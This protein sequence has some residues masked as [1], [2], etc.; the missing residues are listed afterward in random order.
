MRP[1]EERI[2]LAQ[3]AGTEELWKIIRDPHPDV[4]L[5]ATLNRNLEEEMAVFIARRKTTS[6]EALGY[7]ANDIRFK[8]SYKLKLAICRN[9]R[10]PQKVTLSLLKFIRLFDLSDLA[11][12]QHIPVSIRQ[13]IEHDLSQKIP[14]LPSGVKTALAR[15]AGSAVVMMLMEKSDERVVSA[16]L[17]SPVLAEGLLTRT[18]HK[19]TTRPHVILMISEHPKWSLRYAVK[20]ALLR[21]FYTP[22]GQVVR[23]ISDMKTA[24]LRDL[25]GDPKLPPSTRPFIFRELLER[26]EKPERPRDEVFNLSEDDDRVLRESNSDGHNNGEG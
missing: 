15:R 8:E 24:D 2:R 5:H 20:Y 17:D 13:K 26:D 18:I 6:P 4:I 23:F 25:H 3:A 7:L 1:L 11:K 10:S 21:N 12:N 14:S 16:C 19:A 9:P 22:M